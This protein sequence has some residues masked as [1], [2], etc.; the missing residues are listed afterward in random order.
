M[1]FIY[2]RFR[3]KIEYV[4]LQVLDEG[5]LFWFFNNLTVA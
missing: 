1:D 5:I 2:Q 4:L 3:V